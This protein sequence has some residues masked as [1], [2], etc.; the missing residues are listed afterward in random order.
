MKKLVGWW[1]A[2]SALIIGVVLALVNAA[3]IGGTT[4]KVLGAVLPLLGA[5]AVRQTV[6]S[7]TTVEGLTGPPGG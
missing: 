5:G 4:G 6:Y 3:V 1:R 2:E 7:P